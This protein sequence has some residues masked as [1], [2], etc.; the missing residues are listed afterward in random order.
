MARAGR[1]R[2]IG[3]RRRETRAAVIDATVDALA[4]HGFSATSARAVAKRAGV[5]PGAVFYHFGSM[6][7]LLAQV[8][9]TCLDRRIARLRG[10]LDVPAA[11]LPAAFTE[12]VRDDFS[13]AE[14]RALLELV[15]GAITSPVLASRV[16][17]GLDRS[18]AFTREV[19]D[20]LLADSPLASALPLDLVAQV[21]ASAFFG[22]AIMDLVGADVDIDG[23]TSLANL[24]LRLTATGS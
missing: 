20:T 6:D 22:L 8:F 3:G 21:A 13:R 23:M 16:R 24:L 12:A 4:E 7:D 17:E 18:F 10:A 5:A 1:K 9:T 11:G 15:V 14:S 19:I 2:G